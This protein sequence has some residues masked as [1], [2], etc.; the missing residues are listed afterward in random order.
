MRGIG[1]VHIS[2]VTKMHL[3]DNN[4]I[5]YHCHKKPPTSTYSKMWELIGTQRLHDWEAVRQ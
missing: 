4:I 5:P 2:N 1:L 3:E